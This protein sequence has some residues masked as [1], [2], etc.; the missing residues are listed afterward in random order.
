MPRAAGKGLAVLGHTG[1]SC[2]PGGVRRDSLYR[3]HVPE[4]MYAGMTVCSGSQGIHRAELIIEAR[5]PCELGVSDLKPGSGPG[6]MV[7]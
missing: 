3:M 6:G 5:A 4:S 1:F 2:L 7:V